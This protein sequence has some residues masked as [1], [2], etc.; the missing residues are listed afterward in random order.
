MVQQIPHFKCCADDVHAI[1]M[2]SVIHSSCISSAASTTVIL[3][4]C[5][6]Y[7]RSHCDT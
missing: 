2:H 7:S 5:R 1:A 4:S 3:N 6:V